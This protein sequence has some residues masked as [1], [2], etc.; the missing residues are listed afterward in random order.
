MYLL[1]L[2]TS[3]AT[4]TQTAILMSMTASAVCNHVLVAPKMAALLR[5][6]PDLLTGT[7]LIA[8]SRF[9]DLSRIGMGLLGLQI[10]LGAS[11]LF[12]GVRRWY[13]YIAPTHAPRL[14]L[15]GE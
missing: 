11:L 9:E 3:A 8:R 14:S 2:R 7:D 12:L 15:I 1:A 4:L 13:R 6:T 10:A 5:S